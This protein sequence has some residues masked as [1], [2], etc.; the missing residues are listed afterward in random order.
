MAKR[1]PI[2]KAM[3]AI[4][5]RKVILAKKGKGAPYRRVDQKALR[6]AFECAFQPFGG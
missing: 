1:N 2:A 5:K 3:R 6:R 4:H